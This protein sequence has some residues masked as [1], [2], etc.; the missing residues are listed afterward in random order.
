MYMVLCSNRCN[1]ETAASRLSVSWPLRTIVNPFVVNESLFNGLIRG[2]SISRK[3]SISTR[4][5][6]PTATAVLLVQLCIVTLT[7]FSAPPCYRYSYTGYIVIITII[8]VY[9]Y[10]HVSRS[11]VKT[12]T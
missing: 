1:S 3:V 4:R 9:L 5:A 10:S 8:F 7:A 11:G 12:F 6:R 2:T